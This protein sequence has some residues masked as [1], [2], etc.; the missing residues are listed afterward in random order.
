MGRELCQRPEYMARDLASDVMDEAVIMLKAQ[1]L[2][3]SRLAEAMGVSRSHVSKMLNGPPNLTLLSIARLA[4]ALGTRPKIVLEPAASDRDDR[5]VVTAIG[6]VEGR[7]QT[8][9]DRKELGF[10]LFESL[11]GKAV[12][13]HITEDQREL[14]RGAWGKRALVSGKVSRERLS[15]RPVAIHE[16]RSIK[17]LAEPKAPDYRRARGVLPVK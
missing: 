6:L 13:C 12:S 15:G 16:I 17:I 10:T 8:L 3:Q 14:I 7:I 4:A 11:R 1:G 2:T 9:T 5:P